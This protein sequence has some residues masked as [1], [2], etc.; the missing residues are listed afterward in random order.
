[1]AH[2]VFHI[3]DEP[4]AFQAKV[5]KMI[6]QAADA[7]IQLTTLDFTNDDGIPQLDGMDAEQWIDA[8]T[9]ED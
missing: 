9:S 4:A 2:T 6:G 3:E 7:G 8:M 5:Y 1:M